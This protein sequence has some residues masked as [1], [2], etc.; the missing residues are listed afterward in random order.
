MMVF[1]D[2]VYNH[3]GPE[4][5][6]LHLYAPSF[7]TERFHTPWGPAIDFSGP[8]GRQI[9]RFFVD[10]ALY[11]LEEFHIDGLRLDAVHAIF[12]PSASP[13][14]EELAAAVRTGPGREV[15]ENDGNEARLLERDN[16]GRPRHYSAQW[17]DD[18]HHALHVL[19]CGETDGYYGDYARRPAA[20]LGRALAEGF[21]YQGE[22]SAWRGGKKRG[23]A[24]GALPQAAFIG[25]LQNHDQIGNRALG[26]RLAVLTE[27]RALRA[28]TAVL[29]L[30]P[31]LPL[32]FMGQEWG[33]RQPF[34]YFCDFE[35]ELAVRVRDGRCR[36]FGRFA[37]FADPSRLET[38]PDPCSAATF[39]KCVL[40]WDALA[41]EEQRQWL[42]LHRRLLELRHRAIV[43]R[44]GRTPVT[45]RYFLPADRVLRVEWRLKDA[46]L[47]LAANLGGAPASLPLPA[48]TPLYL[49]DGVRAAGEL[50]LPSWSAAF[51]LHEASDA[52]P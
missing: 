39:E 34:F 20:L 18:V 45:G 46:V 13:F 40:D 41:G 33:C 1:L 29:L 12:D 15:L 37:A 8:H 31:Q 7:F 49:S 30:S 17:N 44:L 16:E 2:V 14:L 35:P 28:A 23:S 47:A 21:A 52:G 38:I 6:Y 3:F 19:L 5:N 26:E 50:E 48:G 51:F 10:N 22:V 32:L 25:F 42:D 11:W 43:P 27:P 9:R 4:G 36:E 24:S